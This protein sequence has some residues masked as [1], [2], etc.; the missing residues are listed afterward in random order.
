MEVVRPHAPTIRDIT[1][2]YYTVWGMYSFA[3]GFL[4][5]VYPIFLRSRGLDQFQINV[6]CQ[7]VVGSGKLETL[8][9]F[10]KLAA[11]L[12]PQPQFVLQLEVGG[13]A[14]GAK[15]APPGPAGLRGKR[16]GNT[17]DTSSARPPG[18]NGRPG[19]RSYP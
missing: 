12:Q 19:R 5:G 6:G 17:A 7:L 8:N 16:L 11:A 9:R 15:P 2:R 13:V 18:T 4:F 1:R 14:V 3:G 10:A